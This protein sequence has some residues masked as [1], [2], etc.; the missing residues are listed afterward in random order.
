LACLARIEP[1]VPKG[2]A[3]GDRYAAV[4]MAHLD[5]ERGRR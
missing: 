1:A 2:A 4:Q 5:S 3:T